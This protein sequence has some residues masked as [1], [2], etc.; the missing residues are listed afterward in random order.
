M[1]DTPTPAQ[2]VES[3]ARVAELE[4]ERDESRADAGRA[5]G[6]AGALHARVMELRAQVTARDERI[7][8]LEAQLNIGRPMTSPTPAQDLAAAL[9]KHM[10]TPG[11][12]GWI[13]CACEEPT[14]LFDSAQEWAVHV[15][16]DLAVVIA[17]SRVNH[18]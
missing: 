4:A 16:E 14:L 13:Q 18:V 1:T 6:H 5:H 9:A 2:P 3:R 17:E 12:Q 7:A 11:A 10:P 15:A 8:A